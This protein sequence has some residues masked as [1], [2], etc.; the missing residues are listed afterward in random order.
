MEIL[1]EADEEVTIF[2]RTG[3][4][5][6]NGI[7]NGLQEEPIKMF[8]GSGF[9]NKEWQQKLQIAYF[10]RCYTRALYGGDGIRLELIVA[11]FTSNERPI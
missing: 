11:M 6:N 3:I 7:S 5:P 1:S 4:L 2:L 9:P 8:F 10:S